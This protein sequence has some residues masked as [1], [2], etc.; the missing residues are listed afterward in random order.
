MAT[1]IAYVV[2]KPGVDLTSGTTGQAWDSTITTLKV[3]PGFQ[4]AHCGRSI[5]TPN[6]LMMFIGTLFPKPP[7]QDISAN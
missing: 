3:Q 1:E 2:L 6:L 7:M 4:R 5:E